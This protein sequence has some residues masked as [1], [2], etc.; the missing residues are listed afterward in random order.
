MTPIRF[1]K[2]HA[3]GN[4]FL[5]VLQSDARGRDAATRLR[6]R[7]ATGTPASAPTG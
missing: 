1:A 5:Y 6:A 2:A 3:Y 7:C 4:D